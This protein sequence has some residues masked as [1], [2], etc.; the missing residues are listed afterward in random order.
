LDEIN[1]RHAQS[2]KF[3]KWLAQETGVAKTS[4]QNAT[5]FW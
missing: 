2:Q 3:L 4:A 5:N 1:A